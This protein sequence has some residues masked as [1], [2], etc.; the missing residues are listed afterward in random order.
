[1]I[2]TYTYP[3]LDT[4]K[5]GVSVHSPRQRNSLYGQTVRCSDDIYIQD[6][7]A[8]TPSLANLSMQTTSSGSF[9]LG[10]VTW[11]PALTQP[12]VRYVYV[13]VY[14]W[15]TVT[16]IDLII[17]ICTPPLPRESAHW[18]VRYMTL[19]PSLESSVL[20]WPP[21]FTWIWL[22]VSKFIQ[23]TV[24]YL[25]KLGVFLFGLNHV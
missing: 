6:H 19:L 18:C 10:P 23:L 8:Q 1:M 22:A 3:I 2:S 5:W 15:R 20:R 11:N 13:C 4:Y 14:V 17:T 21:F 7:K 9:L 12:N 16:S 25:I 24:S